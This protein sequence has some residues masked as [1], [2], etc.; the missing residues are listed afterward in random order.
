MHAYQG[1]SGHE[2]ILGK[3]QL[4][5]I[6][7]NLKEGAVRFVSVALF[8]TRRNPKAVPCVK[9]DCLFVYCK[10]AQFLSL[11]LSSWKG[12]LRR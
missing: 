8:I 6:T 10:V 1:D 9:F 11:F 12:V 2:V 5:Q 4:V 3:L 7:N